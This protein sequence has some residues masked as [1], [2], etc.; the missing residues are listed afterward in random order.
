MDIDS[1][2]SG[3]LVCVPSTQDLPY[4]LFAWGSCGDGQLGFSSAPEDDT[5]ESVNV[6]SLAPW[7]TQLALTHGCVAQIAC[8]LRHS[9]ILVLALA[10]RT[11]VV[12]TSTL[13]STYTC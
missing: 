6:P 3:A 9:L 5:T 4:S 10:L 8:G 2:G 13:Q 12:S 7:Y 11:T 1:P